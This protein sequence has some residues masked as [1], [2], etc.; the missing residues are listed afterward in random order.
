MGQIGAELAGADS[1][2]LH[3]AV[4]KLLAGHQD[5]L[6]AGAKESPHSA[7]D[8]LTEAAVYFHTLLE[9]AYLVAS[10][11]GFAEQERAAL[12][13]LIET[14][15]SAALDRTVLLAHFD[16]LD[17]GT[18]MLGR[19]ERLARAA[20][21]IDGNGGREAALRFSALIATANGVM[22]TKELDV[23][24]EMGDHFGIDKGAVETIARDVVAELVE[25]MG[26]AQ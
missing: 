22:A 18:E 9:L 26:G 15:T 2:A 13:A 8:Q 10:A 17:S 14:A 1:E 5:A 6:T 3:A 23:L 21:N 19:R 16:D 7:D 24:V 20:A 12:A 11:D 4:H 25:H